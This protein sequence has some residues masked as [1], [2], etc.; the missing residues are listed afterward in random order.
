MD[1]EAFTAVRLRKFVCE[2]GKSQSFLWDSAAPGLGLRATAKGAKTFIFQ[3]KLNGQ[4]IRLTIGS[5]NTWTIPQAQAEAR[6]LKVLIDNGQDPRKLRAAV[7]EAELQERVAEEAAAAAKQAQEQREALTLG[8]LWPVYIEA[9]RNAKRRGGKVGWSEWH[10][11]DHEVVMRIGGEPKKRGKGLTE[12]GPLA[13]LRDVRL[14]DLTGPRI[15]EWLAKETVKRPTQAGLAF[16]LLSVF[17]NWCAANDKYA[18]LVPVG[19]C[20]SNQVRDEIPRSKA[21]TNDS[22]QRE[23]LAAWFKAVRGMSNTVQ[24]A[25]LQALLL[26]GA[27]RRELA[28]LCWD[29]VD[30]K[31]L[32]LVIR[33]KV[34]G[35]RTIPLCPYVAHLLAALPRRNAFVFSSPSSE[36]GQLAE[37]TP[38]HKRVLAVAG[39]PNVTLHGLRRSFGSL[40]EWVEMPAGVVAQVMEHKPSATAEKHYRE[41]P[42]DL[43][44]MWHTK[45]EQWILSEA[46]IEFTPAPAGSVTLRVVAS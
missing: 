21:K 32:S 30:F 41:R 12:P 16:R 17:M 8:K 34:E 10:I 44:R 1:K 11:R 35:Q 14:V 36:N 37:P 24:S 42:L 23:Q 27:R 40:A 39:L 26:T 4:A 6:R 9:R 20:Q 43:L 22:L 18:G 25:Y 46:G 7:I 15:A 5:P 19:A 45:F 38:G 33:D 13:S 2:E 31:W 29:D 3:A 28:G